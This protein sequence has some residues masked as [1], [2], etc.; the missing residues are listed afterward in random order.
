MLGHCRVP[1]LARGHVRIVS[2]TACLLSACAASL[3]SPA[4]A[5]PWLTVW[6]GGAGAIGEYCIDQESVRDEGGLRYFNAKWCTVRDNWKDVGFEK[7][8]LKHR[9]NCASDFSKEMVFDAWDG[10]KW[11]KSKFPTAPDSA[12]MAAARFVCNPKK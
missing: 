11:D 2:G 12:A 1:N 4:M 8:R 10:Q 9:V 5:E 3:C 6:K 7:H